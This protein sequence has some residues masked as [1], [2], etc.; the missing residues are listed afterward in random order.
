[1][2]PLLAPLLLATPA[3]L[4]FN[5]LY[6][7]YGDWALACD[8]TGHCIAAG[9]QSSANPAPISLAFSRDAGADAA[10][11]AHLQALKKNGEAPSERLTLALDGEPLTELSGDTALDTAAA[12]ALIARLRRLPLPTIH[13]T[14]PDGN[15][16]QLSTQGLRAALLQ[17][18]AYQ[19]R[20]NH[21]SALL[22]P[23]AS[24]SPVPEAQ[25]LP[26][27]RRFI[28]EGEPR[29]LAPGSD[30]QR[31][32]VALINANDP[33]PCR[34][35]LAQYAITLHPLSGDRHLGEIESCFLGGGYNSGNLYIITD[36]AL[37]ALYPTGADDNAILNDYQAG[38][39]TAID[40][41]RPTADC[42]QKRQ[43][44]YNGERFVK[45]A[46]ISHGLC[47]GFTG[48]AWE[49]PT[50]RSDVQPPVE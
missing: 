17:M 45:N 27:I 46:D 9:Y 31:A 6:I 22:Q 16:W 12:N 37:A 29:L 15:A 26:A 23:G 8:N 38:V 20:T 18:D 32:L 41:E 2:K 14:S 48:G 42:W 33:E 7:V 43:Y 40:R 50:Y 3:A 10:V 28:P 49:M 4:A 30:E 25:A 35:P 5:G 11:S 1:M 34:A 21:A 36:S 24:D 44:V 39:L 13:A 47:R 19:Q